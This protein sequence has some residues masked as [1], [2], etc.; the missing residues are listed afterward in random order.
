M[1]SPA[2]VARLAPAAM[3][4]APG[5]ELV[6]F[7]CPRCNHKFD[8]RFSDANGYLFTDL[9]IGELSARK[10]PQNKVLAHCGHRYRLPT[11]AE[12]EAALDAAN[13]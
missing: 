8:D 5:S 10:R 12:C 4:V 2:K 11:E 1:L 9:R 3:T 13:E 7:C 6:E